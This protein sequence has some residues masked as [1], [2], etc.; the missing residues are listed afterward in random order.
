MFGMDVP[1]NGVIM[2]EDLEGFGWKHFDLNFQKKMMA[3]FQDAFPQRMKQ[4]LVMNPPAIMKIIMTLIRPFMK[5]KFLERIKVIKTKELDEYVDLG[6]LHETYGGGIKFSH[7]EWFA[8]MRE[9]E[10]LRA[11]GEYGKFTGKKTVVPAVIKE[12]EEGAGEKDGEE[13][14]KHGRHRH[15]E[16]DQDHEGKGRRRSKESKP[17]SYDI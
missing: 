14:S 2:V 13:R 17:E 5:A 1:R 15:K 7:D 6:Q 4:T 11:E 8:A 12:R 3:V 16:K 10:R 9:V